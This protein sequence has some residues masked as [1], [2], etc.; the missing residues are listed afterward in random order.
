M[1]GM[2]N[3]PSGRTCFEELE[4]ELLRLGFVED[5]HRLHGTLVCAYTTSSEMYGEIGEMVREIHGAIPESAR[6]ELRSEFAACVRAVRIAWPEFA[7]A[8]RK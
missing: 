8:G 5:A 1:A 4:S 6:V 7:I 2:S 3:N